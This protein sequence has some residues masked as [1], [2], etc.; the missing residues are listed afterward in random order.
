L[1]GGVASG[2]GGARPISCGIGSAAFC[3]GSRANRFIAQVLTILL[4]PQTFTT[5]PHSYS[6][7]LFVTDTLYLILMPRRNDGLLTLEF[8]KALHA[9][10]ALLLFH[11]RL[12]SFRGSPGNSLPLGDHL[13]L[14]LQ[15]CSINYMKLIHFYVTYNQS[16]AAQGRKAACMSGFEILNQADSAG[17]PIGIYI[18]YIRYI[19][20]ARIF[21]LLRTCKRS[22]CSRND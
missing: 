11:N 6:W 15:S 8:S 16:F 13:M 19:I 20:R 3:N 7:A 12:E 21:S 4:R 18:V 5:R 14:C 22:Y 17:E 9:C 10:M 1:S 2:A